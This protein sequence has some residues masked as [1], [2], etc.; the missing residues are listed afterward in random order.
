MLGMANM[1]PS[2]IFGDASSQKE[3]L[4]AHPTF[5]FPLIKNVR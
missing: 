1:T 2:G 3:D 5:R 4:T